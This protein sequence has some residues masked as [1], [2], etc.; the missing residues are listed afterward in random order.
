MSVKDD[1]SD[2]RLFESN[3]RKIVRDGGQIRLKT[4]DGKLAFTRQEIA[5]LRTNC[6]SEGL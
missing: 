3:A 5:R 2:A 4:K 1:V 6:Q